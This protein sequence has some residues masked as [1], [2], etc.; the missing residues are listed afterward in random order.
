MNYKRIISDK[1]INFFAL[2]ICVYCVG[3]VFYYGSLNF[4]EYSDSI[5]PIPLELSNK[6]FSL[7]NSVLIS[8]KYN[9]CASPLNKTRNILLPQKNA[10]VFT[11]SQLKEG[12]FKVVSIIKESIHGLVALDSGIDHY[13]LIVEDQNNKQYKIESCDLGNTENDVILRAYNFK[14]PYTLSCLYLNHLLG[15]P[16]F[17]WQSSIEYHGATIFSAT[18]TSLP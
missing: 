12:E 7:D 16:D 1:T 6:K 8:D 2:L 13:Y 11:G 17:G 5:L 14:Q 15:L 3:S 4:C 9:H 10:N 18:T